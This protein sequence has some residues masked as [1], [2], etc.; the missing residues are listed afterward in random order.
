MRPPSTAIHVVVTCMGRL[1]FLRRTAPTVLAHPGPRYCLVDYSCPD[2]CGEWLQSAFASDCETGRAGIEYVPGQVQFNKAKALNTGAR[3]VI[4]DGAEYICFLDADTIVK[5]ELFDWLPTRLTSGR[6]LIVALNHG[7]DV[8]SLTGALVVGARDFETVAGFDESFEGR[9]SEHAEFR[10]RSHLEHGLIYEEMPLKFFSPIQHDDDLRV[11]FYPQ[12]DI[13]SSES[14]DRAKMMAKVEVW[15]RA[16]PQYYS[17]GIRLTHQAPEP[18]DT[19]PGALENAVRGKPEDGHLL[20]RLAQTYLACGRLE[21]A[22][23]AY[24][25]RIA[26]GGWPEEVWCSMYDLGLVRLKL[27][28]HWSEIQST[29]TKAYDFRPE[30]AEPLWMLAACNREL[31]RYDQ[32]YAFAAKALTLSEPNDVLCVDRDVY[33]WRTLSEYAFAAWSVGRFSEALAANRQLIAKNHLPQDE[34]SR[35]IVNEACC[36]KRIQE[37]KEE[38]IAADEFAKG[39]DMPVDLV[40]LKLLAKTA[41]VSAPSTSD[42]DGPTSSNEDT[43]KRLSNPSSVTMAPTC[44][45]SEAVP[46]H[47]ATVFAPKGPDGYE[48]PPS[49]NARGYPYTEQWIPPDTLDDY[50]KNRA[51]GRR[52]KYGRSDIDYQYNSH[53]YRCPE[54]GR[55]ESRGCLRVLSLG[56]SIT[57]GI[58]LPEED[59]WPHRICRYIAKTSNERVINYNLGVPG[60]SNEGIIVRGMQAAQVLQPD[61]IFVQYTFPSRRLYVHENGRV[62][63]WNCLMPLELTSLDPFARRKVLYFTELQNIRDDIARLILLVNL[64]S[65]YCAS[66]PLRYCGLLSF[67]AESDMSYVRQRIMSEDVITEVVRCERTARDLIHPGPETVTEVVKLLAQWYDKASLTSLRH[68]ARARG[69]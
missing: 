26:L 20:F 66:L 51:A 61:F 25:R 1:K 14:G 11:R 41:M 22:E 16:F 36:I 4:A 19:D 24:V 45:H 47:E 68:S 65:G 62:V 59:T 54:F 10:L 57:F 8:P 49:Y 29:L 63:E 31:G 21:D 32:A 12:K 13:G 33:R 50:E 30:R 43:E 9:G 3:R 5:A 6:F 64:F 48:I 35:A 60:S 69:A 28:R 44:P 38:A 7:Y 40:D 55:P 46:Q 42:E 23:T 37:I 39:S 2:R 53:G 15:S 58:G 18:A 17:T 52:T 56:C 67:Q 27:G 34:R